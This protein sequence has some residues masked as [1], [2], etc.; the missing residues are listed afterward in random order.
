MF[1]HIKLVLAKVYFVLH[2]NKNFVATC[3]SFNGSPV[4]AVSWHYY[5]YFPHRQENQCFLNTSLKFVQYV[6]K[7]VDLLLFN[8]A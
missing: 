6:T 3:S 2:Q 7:L 1:Q 8:S 5:L 4:K